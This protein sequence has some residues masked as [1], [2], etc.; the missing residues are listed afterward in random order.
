M[1]SCFG[2]IFTNPLANPKSWRFIAIYS[3]KNFIGFELTFRSLIH[4]E[5][6]HPFARGCPFSHHYLL[7]WFSFCQPCWK[8][9]SIYFWALYFIPSINISIHLSLPRCL[10]CNC[11]VVSCE[12]GTCDCLCFILSFQDY[13]DHFE[14]LQ[15]HMNSR[16]TLSILQVTPAVNLIRI[17]LKL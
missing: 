10:D 13:F 9:V 17:V 2:A 8:S 7:Q 1:S 11:I 5:F 14:F 15:F 3:S 16:N 6:C 4:F 12:I